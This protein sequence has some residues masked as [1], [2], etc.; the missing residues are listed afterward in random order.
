MV[1]HGSHKISDK[2]DVIRTNGFSQKGHMRLSGS[3]I[4][5]FVVAT[6]AGTDEV[7]PNIRSAP[8]TRDDMVHRQRYVRPAAVLAA[9]A[10]SPEDVLSR[11]DD[12]FERNADVDR[13]ANDA[14]KRHRSGDGV[15]ELPVEGG[16]QFGFSKIEQ[17]NRFFD[18]ANAQGLVVMVQDEHFAVNP[19]PWRFGIDRPISTQSMNRCA[20]V[21]NTSSPVGT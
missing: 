12:F 9:M 14:G 20:E 19:N 16:Y 21:S 2:H 4:A 5:F 1:I 18:I 15:K 11:Q 7:L 10:V 8:G 13:K 3:L 6:D 17:N